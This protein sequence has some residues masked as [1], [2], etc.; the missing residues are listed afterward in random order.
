MNDL[1]LNS[2]YLLFKSKDGKKLEQQ[3]ENSNQCIIISI[4]GIAEI[5]STENAA[6]HASKKLK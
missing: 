1:L 5:S 3:K 6:V 4:L 2:L